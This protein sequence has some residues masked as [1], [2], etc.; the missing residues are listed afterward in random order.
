MKITK[1]EYSRVFSLGNYENEKIGVEVEVR[2]N[3]DAADA[4]KEAK[5]FVELSSHNSQEKIKKALMIVKN[6]D[7]YQGRSVKEAL[8]YLRSIDYKETDNLIGS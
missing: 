5:K 4:L 3:E 6:P 1:I 8:E 7:D 2:E